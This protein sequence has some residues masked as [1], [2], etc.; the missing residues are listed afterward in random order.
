MTF[1]QRQRIEAQGK[2]LLGIFPD[3][4][5]RDPV[6]LCRKLR[7]LEAQGGRLALALCNSRTEEDIDT[8]FAAVLRDVN[9][10]LGNDFRSDR[11]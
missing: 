6:E 10:L 11:I 2:A 9:E 5:E 3:A 1:A 8:M 7:R 4:T